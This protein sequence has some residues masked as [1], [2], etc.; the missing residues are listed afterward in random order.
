MI[1]EL[2]SSYPPTV[3]N[4]YQKTQRGLFISQKGRKFRDQLCSDFHEQLSGMEPIQGKVR[5]DVIAWVPDNRR[6]DLDNIMKPIMDAMT[7][8]G[9]WDDDSQVDQMCVYRGAKSAPNGAIYIRVDEAAPIIPLGCESL[10]DS[11]E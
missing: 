7:H 3:N 10:L 4:Y 1:C 11:G 8:A 5:I 2:Y 9:M 6:R